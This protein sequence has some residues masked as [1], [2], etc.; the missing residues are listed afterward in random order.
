MS[1]VFNFC[2]EFKGIFSVE[3]NRNLEPNEEIVVPIVSSDGNI[4]EKIM[5]AFRKSAAVLVQGHG[6]FLW[7]SSRYDAVKQFE[8]YEQLFA[9]ANIMHNQRKL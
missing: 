3:K 8:S 6:L 1:I 5:A 4:E 7:S 9:I 2:F